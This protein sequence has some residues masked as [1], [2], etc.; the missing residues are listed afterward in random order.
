[1]KP[2]R[3]TIY[4]SLRDRGLGDV[5]LILTLS[6]EYHS[7][8]ELFYAFQ[9]LVE[10]EPFPNDV[11]L[12]W[13]DKHPPL[14]FVS[15]KTFPPDPDTNTLQ[16]VLRDQAYPILRALV[17]SANELKIAA[18]AGLEKVSGSIRR[19]GLAD[20]F[21]LL[22]LTALS[23]RS[24]QLVQEVLLVLN[25]CRVEGEPDIAR[26]YGYKHA[27]AVAFDVAEEAADECPCNEDGR[28][29]RQKTPPT[30][31]RLTRIMGEPLMVKA[32]IRV[33]A[34]TSA[35]LH[36]HVRLEASSK[37]EN[38]WISIPIVDGLVIQA[39]K[40]ELKIELLH[41][42][43]PETESM[44]WNLY[45]AGSIGKCGVITRFLSPCNSFINSS[46]TARAMMDALLRLLIE[47]EECCSFY[48]VITGEAGAG[49][50][51]AE[52]ETPEVVDFEPGD[53]LNDSQKTAVLSPSQGHLSLIW[54]PPGNL[55]IM[56]FLFSEL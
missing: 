6:L 30:Q 1:L 48:S 25:D 21:D 44:D 18:L 43:P 14:V 39:G 53:H 37:P 22:S 51:T 27:L 40:G 55:L 10:R 46:A 23:V 12:S 26:R 45:T 52:Q 4:Q 5:E 28:P 36:S 20:Y 54:G 33:D 2:T 24:Q 11:V 42:P 9:H 56:S 19:I 50:A 15:L 17:H 16:G 3:E 29:R 31:T 7:E 41:P 38:R 49:I 35:R 32:A 13:I 47:R 8:D 34:R